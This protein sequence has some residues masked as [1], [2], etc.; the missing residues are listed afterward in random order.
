[1]GLSDVVDELHNEHSLTYTGT[2]EETDLTTTRV[3][4]DEI[5]DLDTSKQ[6]IIRDTELGVLRRKGVDGTALSVDR[7]TLIDGLTENVHDTTKSGLTNGNGNSLSA[8]NDLHGT[9]ETVGR[10]ESDATN[11]G[12]GHNRGNLKNEV[13]VRLGNIKSVENRRDLTLRELYVNDG[14]DHLNDLTDDGALR[15]GNLLGSGRIVGLL[16]VIDISLGLLGLSGVEAG[17]ASTGR[18]SETARK[19]VPSRKKKR[20]TGISESLEKF[21]WTNLIFPID[22]ILIR[23]N[24]WIDWRRIC[25]AGH[26]TGTIHE[27]QRRRSQANQKSSRIF[28][29]I[30]EC[31]H[32]EIWKCSIRILKCGVPL[33][34]WRS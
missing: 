2:T 8:V 29:G 9:R 13:I 5:Y 17:C 28:F 6:N 31:H 10:V 18:G 11:D 1:V 19:K 26:E 30:K 14:T 25:R 33:T 27:Q 34:R 16:N 24:F 3:G 32:Y 4:S 15:D 23:G 22:E 20:S 12:L 7:S 21:N